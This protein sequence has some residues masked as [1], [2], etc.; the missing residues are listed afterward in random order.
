MKFFNNV[1]NDQ[2]I[3]QEALHNLA[4]AYLSGL[5]SKVSDASPRQSA[6]SCP[7]TFACVGYIA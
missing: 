1:F 4:P 5:P 3:A 6:L 7:Q 2:G